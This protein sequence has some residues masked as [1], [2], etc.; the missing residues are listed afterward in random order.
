M[1]QLE[2]P[3]RPEP[4]S[5][6]RLLLSLRSQGLTSLSSVTLHQNRSVMVS[7]GARGHLRLHRGYAWAPDHV[8]AA[9]AEFLR[10]GAR[11]AE[12]AAARTTLLAFPAESFAPSPRPLVRRPEAPRPGDAPL[13]D[14]LRAL[15]DQLNGEYFGGCLSRIPIRL[16]GRMHRRLGELRVDRATGAAEEI[17]LARR[18]LRRD[19]WEAVRE[20]MLHEMVH[21]WQAES[22]RPVDHGREFRRMARRVGIDPRAMKRERGAVSRER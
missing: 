3:L 5:P 16:S 18:H 21:Q 15:H 19:G 1:L 13:L 9:V 8:L 4:V 12:R 17:G 7:L 14:R 11:R 6:D 22:A 20:T 10:P 2:L